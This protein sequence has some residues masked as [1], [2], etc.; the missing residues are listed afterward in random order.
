M[1]WGLSLQY[2]TTI[3]AGPSIHNVYPN[4]STC[5]ILYELVFTFTA[6]TGSEWVEWSRHFCQRHRLKKQSKPAVS[7]ARSNV[8]GDRLKTSPKDQTFY[9]RTAKQHKVCQLPP[10]TTSLY[11]VMAYKGQITRDFPFHTREI[12]CFLEEMPGFCCNKV[13]AG[14]TSRAC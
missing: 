1:L 7:L 8:Y 6:L 3:S 2:Y 13:V 11:S 14:D 5:Q 4:K 9:R 10:T 12:C